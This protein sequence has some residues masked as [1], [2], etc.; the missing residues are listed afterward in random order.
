MHRVVLFLGCLLAIS[1]ACGCQR[2]PTRVKIVV[3]IVGA[4]VKLV[5]SEIADPTA[6]ELRT[7][8]GLLDLRSHS[9]AG[10]AE[11]Y[12]TFDPSVDPSR[13]PGLLAGPLRNASRNMLNGA[14]APVVNVLTPGDVIPTPP[15][16]TEPTVIVALNHERISALG[17][18]IEVASERLT[19]VAEPVTA[20]VRRG[21]TDAASAEIERA[22]ASTIP[23][24]DAEVRVGELGAFE[25]VMAPICIVREW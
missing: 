13:I 18:S 10:R 5:D 22:E 8:P 14:S 7:V 19:A 17:L 4:D 20:A 15:A 24:R 9:Y 21:D 16:G 3:E 25:V 23:V 2:E 1:V 12:A 11:I 6:L